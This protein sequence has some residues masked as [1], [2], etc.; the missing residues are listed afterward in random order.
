MTKVLSNETETVRVLVDRVP[1]SS[2]YVNDDDNASRK[3]PPSAKDTKALADDIADRGQL[4]PVVVKVLGGTDKDLELVD[5]GYGYRLL[6]GYNRMKAMGDIGVDE[7]L[8]R[9]VDVE[10]GAGIILTNIAENMKRTGVSVIDISYAIGRLV[11]GEVAA[12]QPE[13]VESPVY[14]RE[15]MTLKKVAAS[16]SIGFGYASELNKFRSL[17]MPIQKKIHSG[18]IKGVLAR[19]LTGMMEEQQDAVLAKLEEGGVTQNALATH[20]RDKKAAKKGKAKRKGSG[21]GGG[22]GEGEG[23]GGGG[24]R[25]VK[26]VSAKKAILVLEELA[27]KPG[28]NEEGNTVEESAEQKT[29]RVVFGLVKAFME[30]KKGQQALQK[31][32]LKALTGE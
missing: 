9:I 28:K 3:F 2:I 30:G 7:V 11:D 14:L 4:Q 23:E 18:D 27:A 32:V 22:D 31:G 20:I 26:P 10:D 29:A 25:V 6:A 17:R 16:L 24:G 8:I 1:F 12:E 5:Q 19:E 13:G 15:P 21:G